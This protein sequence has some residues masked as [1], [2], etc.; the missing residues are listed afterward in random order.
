MVFGSSRLADRNAPGADLLPVIGQ[1][2]GARRG[3]PSFTDDDVRAARLAPRM[4]VSAIEEAYRQRML[5][6]VGLTPKVGFV[7][8]DGG[9][10]HAMPAMIGDLSIVKWVVC[11]YGRSLH[12]TLMASNGITGETVAILDASWLTGLRTAAVSS[13]AALRFAKP[14]SETIAFV[15]CGL[16]ARTHLLVLRELFPIRSVIASSRRTETARAFAEE[17]ISFGLAAQVMEPGNDAMA[18]ADIVV[19]GIPLTTSVQP[20]LDA[21]SL[22]RDCFV[23]AVDHAKSWRFETVAQF[24]HVVTDDR[25]HTV[26][27]I[28]QGLFSFPG[29][30]DLD[31]HELLSRDVAPRCG[32]TIMIA[33]GNALSDAAVVRVA[34]RH[35]IGHDEAPHAITTVDEGLEP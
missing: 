13:A 34:L 8:S 22:P 31:L 1:G 32:R 29:A 15:G 18:A 27:M 33:P 2:T 17:A 16:Q 10:C 30:I 24:D 28:D 23:A 3:Y 12:A 20:F 25:R 21:G 6:T 9:F 11:G 19:T 5:P 26:G 4:L 7:R 14:A 35:L